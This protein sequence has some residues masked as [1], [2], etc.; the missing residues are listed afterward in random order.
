MEIGIQADNL[1]CVFDIDDALHR[2]PA[3]STELSGVG[4]GAASRLSDSS[5]DSSDSDTSASDTSG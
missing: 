4:V 3:R 1:L 5:T 2:Q